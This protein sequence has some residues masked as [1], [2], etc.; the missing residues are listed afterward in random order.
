M[1][2]YVLHFE[3]AI[4][5][6]VEG[7]AAAIA[8][9]SRVLDAGAGEGQYAGRFT[10]HRYVGVDLGVGDAAWDYRRLDAI[11]DLRALPFP[12]GEFAGAL[13][14]VTLEHVTDPQAVVSELARVLAPAGRLLLIVP[15]EWE[16]HQHPHDYFR[17]TRFGCR[18]LLERAGLTIDSIVPVGGYFRLLSRRLLSGYKFFPAPLSWLWLVVVA[19]PAL[20]LP[21]LDGL[22]RQADYTLGYICH[23][24]KE[25]KSG[26][27]VGYAETP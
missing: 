20:L 22:D 19:G 25:S 15:H 23:A 14:V 24:H 18:L 26:Y 7:F 17:Y 5:A 16:V 9:G 1:K 12:D 4:A 11:A 10:A 3:A 8:P 13:N 21:L 27:A 6:A 2:A